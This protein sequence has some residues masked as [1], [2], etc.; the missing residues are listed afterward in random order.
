MLWRHLV[1]LWVAPVVSIPGM[2]TT[3]PPESTVPLI[4]ALVDE[5]LTL[6]HAIIDDG[7]DLEARDVITPLYAAQEYVRSSKQRHTLLRKLLG[8]GALRGERRSGALRGKRQPGLQIR[9]SK[10]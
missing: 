7:A 6:A 2:H 5:N 10:F 4:Q 8:R 1:L 9:G 3:G